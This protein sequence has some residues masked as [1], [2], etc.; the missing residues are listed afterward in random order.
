MQRVRGIGGVFFKAKD[1]A[2]LGTW[3][4]ENLGIPVE[5]WGGHGFTWSEHDPK[6]DAITVWSPMPETTT[7]YEPST[8]PFMINF[9]VDDLD[10]MLLQLR[11]KGC[12]V[13]DKLEESEYGR[14][15][16]VMDPEGNRVELWQPP[17]KAPASS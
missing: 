17:E 5:P 10:A 9:R 8:K 2:A 15:G 7:Y 3:Y 1:P 12:E 4:R 14:F 16:W 13:D 6:G 11:E